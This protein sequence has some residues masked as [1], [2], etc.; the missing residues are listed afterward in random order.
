MVS[1][2][3]YSTVDWKTFPLKI[4]CVKIFHRVKFLWLC[5]TIDDYSTDE[6]QCAEVLLSIVEVTLTYHKEDSRFHGRDESHYL[7]EHAGT[8]ANVIDLH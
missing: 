1:V 2:R 4:I 3:S 5:S 7:C 6:H 8:L